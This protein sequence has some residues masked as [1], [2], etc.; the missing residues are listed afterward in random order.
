MMYNGVQWDTGNI[1]RES[2]ASYNY[3][4]EENNFNIPPLFAEHEVHRADH[5]LFN[6]KSQV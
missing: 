6:D 3:L 2:D 4:D 5:R 1:V